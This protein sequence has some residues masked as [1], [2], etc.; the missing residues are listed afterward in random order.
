MERPYDC[1]D[2]RISA[3]TFSVSR[4]GKYSR[5]LAFSPALS[6][7]AAIAKVEEYLSSPLAVED[8]K[9]VEDDLFPGTKASELKCFADC[10]SDCI[11]LE[12]IRQKAPG[13]IVL[14]CGS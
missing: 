12:E 11:F 8:I 14:V 4:Y 6:E 1:K 10:I 9:S 7:A 5:T 2:E 13:H 3:V